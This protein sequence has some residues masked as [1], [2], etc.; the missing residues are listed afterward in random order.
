MRSPEN[1]RGA[2]DQALASQHA[3]VKEW[4]REFGCFFSKELHRNNVVVS[5]QRLS[6]KELEGKNRC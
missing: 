4:T 3:T 6:E 1:R 2:I 5:D